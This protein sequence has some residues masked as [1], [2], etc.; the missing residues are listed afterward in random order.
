MCIRA[1]RGAV[2]IKFDFLPYICPMIFTMRCDS[3]PGDD[4]TA[5]FYWSDHA[6]DQCRCF[7]SVLQNS[8]RRYRRGGALKYERC[9]NGEVRRRRRRQCR[10]SIKP[11]Q[12]IFAPLRIDLPP[13]INSRR[14][15]AFCMSLIA[16][17]PSSCTSSSCPPPPLSSSTLSRPLALSVV[18][19]S[20]VE[21]YLTQPT[22]GAPLPPSSCPR[23]P[24]TGRRPASPERRG[25]RGGVP[26]A[27]RRRPA[28]W[29]GL[30]AEGYWPPAPSPPDRW[31]PPVSHVLKWV[32]VALTKISGV[33][34]EPELRLYLLPVKKCTLQ[35]L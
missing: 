21:A 32:A 30:T 12:M 26:A 7:T 19:P 28:R 34:V 23:L 1:V 14:P 5:R 24:P 33:S 22:G 25:G 35:I 2:R 11:A 29:V 18:K 6:P 16:S 15:A 27:W 8:T 10:G 17:C 3:H 9:L 31:A 4:S 20:V 13:G